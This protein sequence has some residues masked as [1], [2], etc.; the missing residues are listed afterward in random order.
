MK[1]GLC[2]V[3]RKKLK[4]ELNIALL[5]KQLVFDFVSLMLFSKLK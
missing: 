4:D 1:K 2:D 5:K 3:S